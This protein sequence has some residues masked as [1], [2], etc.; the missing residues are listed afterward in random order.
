M[1]LIPHCLTLLLPIFA[2]SLTI[3]HTVHASWTSLV[4]HHFP[5]KA[6]QGV[7]VHGSTY[8]FLSADYCEIIVL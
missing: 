5:L 8:G 3:V 2:F 6:V 7:S 4:S 1:G